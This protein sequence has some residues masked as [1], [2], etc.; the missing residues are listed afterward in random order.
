LNNSEEYDE[1]FRQ[2][3]LINEARK[4]VPGKKIL[5]ALDADE[6]LSADS[7]KSKDWNRIRRAPKGSVL[8]FE[9][10]DLFQGTKLVLRHSQY[11]PIGYI[12]DGQKHNP[13]KLHSIRI[14]IHV[15]SPK[16]KL[17]NIKFLHY[18]LTCMRLQKAKDRL[19][20]VISNLE[21]DRSFLNAIRRRFRHSRYY[22]YKRC[23]NICKAPASWFDNW[24]RVNI[25][26]HTI[27]K[28]RFC[29]QD[30]ELLR[31][32]NKHGIKRFWLDDIFQDIKLEDCREFFLNKGFTGIPSN[33]ISF[34]PLHFRITLFIID[35]FIKLK[36]N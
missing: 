19:Y 8:Y 6:I 33:H 11:F 7:L 32:I 16:I 12:D 9:K 5:L 14:P 35:C 21:S 25:D 1:A 28:E 20:S 30:L 36:N 3:L 18:G 10:P 17:H 23:G 29:S 2:N 15:N 24:E 34:P 22:N 4:L 13:H 27:K 26:M 31:I